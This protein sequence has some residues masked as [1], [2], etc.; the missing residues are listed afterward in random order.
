MKKIISLGLVLG[1]MPVMAFAAGPTVEGIL[2]QL[3][4]ILNIIMPILI[5]FAAVYFVWGVVQFIMSS[6]EEKKKG[7]RGKIIQGLIGL[8]VI[9]AFWGILGVVM[10]TFGVRNTLDENIVPT[11]PCIEG[12]P[13]CVGGYR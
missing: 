13:G 8:F 9:I 7:A 4:G 2:K 1:A 11:I 10:R 6:D 12:T 3:S 5:A